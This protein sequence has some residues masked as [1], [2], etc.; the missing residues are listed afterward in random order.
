MKEKVFEY[1]KHLKAPVTV[2]EVAKRVNIHPQ[3]A[4]RILL[5]LAQEGK[6]KARRSTSKIWLFWI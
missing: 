6:I 2:S 4:K 5:E 1:V 3:T